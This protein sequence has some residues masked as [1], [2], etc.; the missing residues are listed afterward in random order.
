MVS[1]KATSE[2]SALICKIADRAD[3]ITALS[4]ITKDSMSLVMDLTA[5]N[6]NGCPMDFA[7]LLSAP[8][9]DFVHDIAGINA[10]IDRNTGELKDY[11]LPR[12]AK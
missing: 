8:D 3:T 5:T 2:D 4:G 9:L 1:F 10:H 12:C 11:F 6:A 7:K